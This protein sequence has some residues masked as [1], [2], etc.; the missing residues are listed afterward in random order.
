MNF[1]NNLRALVTGGTRGLGQ[2]LVQQLRERGVTT[3]SL[4]RTADV[5]DPLFLAADV[6]RDDAAGI[7]ARARELAGGPIDILI[8]NASTLGPVPMPALADLHSRDL[9]HVFE[10]N[11]LGPARLTRALLGPMRAQGRGLILAISSDAAVHGYAGWGAYGASKAALDSLTRSLAAEL[12]GTGVAVASVDPTEMNT[13]MHRDALPDVDPG[14]L[15]SP[16]DIASR[17]LTRVQR[18][19]LPLRFVAEAV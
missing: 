1:D 12:E 10:V 14:T 8:H 3:V 15:A 18:T 7:A 16:S 2:A 13:K 9:A 6:G 5:D 4:A 19:P 17:I 11:T